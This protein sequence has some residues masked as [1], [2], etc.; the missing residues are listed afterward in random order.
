MTKALWPVLAVLIACS[1]CRGNAPA[2]PSASGLPSAGGAPASPRA[3]AS[4]LTRAQAA[5]RYLRIVRPYNAA[6][7]RFQTAAHANR[8]W[9]SLRILAR[10]IVTAN[11][12]QIRALRTT[13]WPANAR[14]HVTALIAVSTRAGRC[15]KAAANATGPRQFQTAV[16]QAARLSGKREATALRQALGL[17]PYRKS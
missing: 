16:L 4:V 12:V 15:W 1:A 13:P 11:T 8:S 9:T 14:K 10:Q 5:T 6:L 2:A 17:P 3:T 7:E